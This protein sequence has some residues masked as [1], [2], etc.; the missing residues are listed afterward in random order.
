[1]DP[2][3]RPTSKSPHAKATKTMNVLAVLVLGLHATTAFVISTDSHSRSTTAT[4]VHSAKAAIGTRSTVAASRV[5]T[6]RMSAS[7]GFFQ[8][9][10][11]G[12]KASS[13]DISL[14]WIAW[15][16]LLCTDAWERARGV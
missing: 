9:L 12:Q 7:T 6:S 15:A 5:D 11:G 8:S 2:S 10:F 4:G 3:T 1:M 13:D 14:S 16:I